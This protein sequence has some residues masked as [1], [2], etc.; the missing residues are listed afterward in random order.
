MKKKS[1]LIMSITDCTHVQFDLSMRKSLFK[2][3]NAQIYNQHT[4]E[5]AHVRSLTLS[6]HAQL[7]YLMTIWS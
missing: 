3:I 1:C 7:T 2:I 5:I 6:G 4:D